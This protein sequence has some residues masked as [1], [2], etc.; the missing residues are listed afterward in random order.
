MELR[1]HPARAGFLVLR[2]NRSPH[3]DRIIGASSLGDSIVYDPAQCGYVMEPAAWTAL[4]GQIMR[5]L[6]VAP[7]VVPP[8]PPPRGASGHRSTVDGGGGGGGGLPPQ[9]S[10]LMPPPAKRPRV[11][12]ETQT[13]PTPGCVSRGTQT[14]SGTIAAVDH[15]DAESSLF[16][17]D[18]SV[19][20]FGGGDGRAGSEEG[21]EEDDGDPPDAAPT[22]GGGGRRHGREEEEEESVDG[23][24]IALE[25]QL[26]SRPMLLLPEGRMQP[27]GGDSPPPRSARVDAD[28]ESMLSGYDHFPEVLR[29]RLLLRDVLS[30]E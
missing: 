30:G 22:V 24:A 13:D 16:R 25:S 23:R 14:E 19:V 4:R 17:A 6:D 18:E 7:S 2:A 26:L 12:T 27:S 8:P 15:P 3:I 9:L 21:E 5:P 11:C 20:R 28:E 1:V 29:R 10:P